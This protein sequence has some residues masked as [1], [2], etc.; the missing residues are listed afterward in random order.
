M[1]RPVALSVFLSLLT[2]LSTQLLQPSWSMDLT[3]MK[4]IGSA[5]TFNKMDDGF[6]IDCADKS[7][8][9]VQV[10]APDLVRIRASFKKPLPS[11][12]HSW[13][14]EKTKWDGNCI[15]RVNLGG[16]V[17]TIETSDLRV[18]VDSKSMRISFYDAQSGQLINS[19]SMPIQHDPTSGAVAASK[20]LGFEEHFYGLG[21]KAANLDKRRS[22]FQMWSSDTPGYTSTTDPIYQSIPFYVGLAMDKGKDGKWLGN[23]YGIFFDNSHRTYF[24]FASTDPENVVF[25]ADGG[26]INYYF[27]Y[28]P[29]MK[30]VV[31]RYTEL[32]GRMP[33]PPKWALGHQQSRYSYGNEQQIKDVVTRYRQ[34]DIPLDVIHFDIHYM[35]GYRDFTWNRG[36]FPDPKGLMKWLADR[37]V[38][39]VTIIDPGVKYEPG[40]N[41][42]VYN[43]GTAKNYFLKKTNG[44]TYV[45]KVWPGDSVFVD[46]TLPEAARWWGD[47]HKTLLDIGVSGIWNDMNEPADFE[48]RDGDKWRDVVNYDD[49]QYS[50]HDKMR[51]LFGFL[52]C[53]ATYE[54]LLRLRPNERPYIIT[55]SGYAGIQRY[56]T[57]WT[58]DSPS[59]WS[60]LALSIPMFES[61]GLSGETFVGSDCGGYMYR[62]DGE[63]LTRWYQIGFLSPF[64]RNHH[65]VDYYDQ[66]PWRFGKRYEDIMRQYVQLRYHLMPYLYTVLAEAHETGLPWFRPLILEYQD[67]YN[68]LNIDDQ[69]MVGSALLVAPILQA[70]AT[71]R[72]VYLPDGDWYNYFTGK[73]FKGG[74]YIRVHAPLDTVPMFV[75]AGS[76]LAVGP[77]TNHIA[78]QSKESVTYEVFPDDQGAAAGSL[79]IDDGATQA[80]LN[81]ACEHVSLKYKDGRLTS[82]SLRDKTE[83]VI[84]ASAIKDRSI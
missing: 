66:E 24:D 63:L 2:A 82:V 28:G 59:T 71:T 39:A 58:G 49:G 15:K 79:Y 17:S 9:R 27:I 5:A 60:A 72:D 62:C 80:Y 57:M 4:P 55:R 54:G 3:G 13:A 36:R 11:Y 6:I 64:F 67:D 42:S 77:V 61:L 10:L 22:A 81:G 65:A 83:Q 26:E 30:K 35:D 68:A 74:Q 51:N 40:G 41:Y 69:F 29:C 14:V 37:G 75:K 23:A 46:Y 25:K 20:S 19:D 73:K 50:K 32:T 33:L 8:L 70:G 48:S 84:P 52:E 1:R 38:K 31:G 45:G 43:E 47:Q 78:E 44:Q 76:V 53:K 56:A 12:D 34:E 21:E 18:A 7:E 16:D